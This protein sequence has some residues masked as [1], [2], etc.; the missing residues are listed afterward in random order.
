MSKRCN[1]NLPPEHNASRLRA[2]RDAR[3]MSQSALAFR[4]RCSRRTISDFERG[5]RMPTARQTRYLAAY[6]LTSPESLFEGGEP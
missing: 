1:N 3:G 6:L 5:L 2:V 4:I